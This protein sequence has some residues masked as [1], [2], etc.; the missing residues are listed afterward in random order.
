MKPKLRSVAFKG[1][2]A[3]STGQRDLKQRWADK[4]TKDRASS[5]NL[6]YFEEELEVQ[7]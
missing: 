1:A 6:S 2:S 4:Y 7:A 5:S 3:P